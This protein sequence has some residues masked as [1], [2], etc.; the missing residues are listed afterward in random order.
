MLDGKTNS[1]EPEPMYTI[2]GGDGQKYGPVTA[3]ELR[4]WI[5]Q[6]RANSQT[7]TQAEDGVWKPLAAF[8]ELMEGQAPTPQ[9]PPMAAEP[10]YSPATATPTVT[11]IRTNSMAIAA[12]VLSIVGLFCCGPIFSTIGLIL[13]IVA[14]GQIN[15]SSPPEG[16]K[17][18]AIAAIA[19]AAVGYLLFAIFILS[20]AWQ[21]LLRSLQ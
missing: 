19:V 2:V 6:G 11:A 1:S 5:S 20:G 3:E 4:R 17:G 7:L 13:G 10:V 21:E 12:L 14:I 16:G 8:P 9:P 18:L 15:R